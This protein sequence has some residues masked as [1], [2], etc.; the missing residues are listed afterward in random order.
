MISLRRKIL[1][2]TF[3]IIFIIIT[4]A[5]ALYATGYKINLKHPLSLKLIQKTGMI[6]FETEPKEAFIYIEEKK[7]EELWGKILFKQ[8]NAIRTPAKIKGL[9]PDVYDTRLELPG[10]WPWNKKLKVNPGQITHAQN[11]KL[12]KKD[13]PM[14]IVDSPMQ[15]LFASSDNKKILL[16][17][18]GLIINL[19]TEEQIE[20]S[21]IKDLKKETVLWSEDN[22]KI[23]IDNF[24][25]NSKNYEKTA[26]LEKLIGKNIK[27][28]KWDKN[29]LY[30]KNK[31]TLNCFDINSNLNKTLIRDEDIIDYEIKNSWIIFISQIQKQTRLKIY[32]K[33]EEKIIK[34]IEL[35]PS[36]NYKL[37][38]NEHHLVNIYDEKY[39]ILYLINPF[40]LI[41][42]LEEIISNIKYS[43]WLDEDNLLYA[44]NF[45]IWT[46]DLKQ[47]KKNLLTRI[48]NPITKIIKTKINNHIIYSTPK[49]IN[50]LDRDE[51]N[52]TQV[53]KLIEL[54]EISKPIFDD[55]ENILYFNAKIGDTEGLYKLNI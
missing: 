41:N 40:S 38:N 12:F 5:I 15:E 30:Y 27:N 47:N 28:I 10:Y 31:D 36:P 43:F 39:K 53:T 37:I 42:P 52:K 1:F 19:K 51:E 32:S 3:I 17:K 11:I 20:L 35:P 55:E 46:L 45:E 16:A 29:K 18:K 21:E 44:N 34:N 23:L 13:L 8:D 24:I 33:N 26:D 49:S 25:F 6:I 54:D 48:S 14:K 50:I 4:P 7:Q 9:L 22:K 2:Y